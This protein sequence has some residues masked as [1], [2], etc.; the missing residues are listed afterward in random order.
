MSKVNNIGVFYAEQVIGV[1]D[2]LDRILVHYE[3]FTKDMSP[4][5]KQDIDLYLAEIQNA[6]DTHNRNM[7]D[8]KIEDDISW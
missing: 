8:R 5:M 6:L 2:G 4:A 1:R 7:L 3:E